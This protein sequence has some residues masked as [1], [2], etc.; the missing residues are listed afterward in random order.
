MKLS[1]S[2]LLSTD[3]PALAAS[4]GIP[5]NW[6]VHFGFPYLRPTE[7]PLSFWFP[8]S[9]PVVLVILLGWRIS[10]IARL[11]A[12]GQLAVGFVTRLNIARDRGRLEFMFE[13]QG[14]PISTWTPIDKTKAVLLLVPGTVVDVLFDPSYPTRAIVKDLYTA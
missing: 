10:R 7:S 4:L 5:I 6:L 2:K 3:F 13:Y 12:H 1:L 9:I 14:K 8:V 11:F